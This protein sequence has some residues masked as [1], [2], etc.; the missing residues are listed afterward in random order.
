MISRSS[1]F[2]KIAL[3]RVGSSCAVNTRPIKRPQ[4][5]ASR[6]RKENQGAISPS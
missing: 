6:S 5:K 1:F 4:A 2:E 3:I